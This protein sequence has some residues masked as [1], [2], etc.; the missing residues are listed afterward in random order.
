MDCLSAFSVALSIASMTTANVMRVEAVSAYNVVWFGI[1]L[2]RTIKNSVISI[3]KQILKSH[4][5]SYC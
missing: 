4:V 2:E 1:V 3:S 5:F